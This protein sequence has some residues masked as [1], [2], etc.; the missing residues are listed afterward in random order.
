MFYHKLTLSQNEKNNQQSIQHG[1]GSFGTGQVLLNSRV[2]WMPRTV[3]GMVFEADLIVA[4]FKLLD[5]YA[6]MQGMK[7]Y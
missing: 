2:W 4:F 7:G 1:K 6:D 3:S 5:M